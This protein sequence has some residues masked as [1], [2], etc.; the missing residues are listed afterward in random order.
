MTQKISFVWS[1]VL[2][3]IL[4]LTTQNGSLHCHQLHKSWWEVSS[5]LYYKCFTIVMTLVCIIKIELIVIDDP[6]PSL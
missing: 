6:S 5:G 4:E 3:S 2:I 1:S